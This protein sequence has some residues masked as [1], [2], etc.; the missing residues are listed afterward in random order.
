MAG[1][2]GEVATTGNRRIGA[3]VVRARK[4]RCR[5]GF[6]EGPAQVPNLAD[7]PLLQPLPHL[8]EAW[9]RTPVI[10]HE[11]MQPGIGKHLLH[12]ATLPGVER[13]RFLDAAML[14]GGGHLQGIGVMAVGRCGDVYGVDFGIVDQRMRIGINPRDAVARGVVGDGFQAP[15][16]HRHQRRSG[17]LVEGRCAFAFSDTATTNHAPTHQVHRLSLPFSRYAMRAGPV[18]RP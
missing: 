6:G 12:L 13:H 16:H 3:P 9:Q 17:R 7:P 15:P 5:R 14:A 8:P 1:Q 11:Q 2:I 10:G 18:D 4:I